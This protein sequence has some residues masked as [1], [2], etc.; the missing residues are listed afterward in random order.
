[1]Q[2]P[3]NTENTMNQG[4]DRP[5]RGVLARIGPGRDTWRW[6]GQQL[7]NREN[8]AMYFDPLLESINPLWA[9]RYIPARVE[10]IEAE[11]HDSKT[12]TLR[13]ARRW[14][15]FRAGQHL[16]L[17][18]EKDGRWYSRPF[19]LSCA[20][21]HWE[22]DGTITVTIKK[23]ADGEI[24]PWLLENFEPGDVIGISRA[25]GEDHTPEPG[26]PMLFI[27][28]GSGIT[29]VLSQLEA[30]ADRHLRNPVTLLYFVRTEADVIGGRK[31]EALAERLPNL[32][33]RIV[34]AEQDPQNPDHLGP[35]HLQAVEGLTE[36]ECFL[37]GPPGLM[38]HAENL[39]A[40]AGV[41]EEQVRST[42]FAVGP[43]VVVTEDAG[44]TVHFS[45]SDITV[46]SAGDRR[47]LE[48]AEAAGLN[49]R[50]G[51]RMGICHQCACRKK[52]GIVINQQTGQPSGHGEETVQLCISVPQGAVELEL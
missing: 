6:L 15:G 30:M 31:L 49:P 51:C 52:S 5:Y 36:R 50:Y 43:G 44:G 4:L 25:Y 11:T 42:L 19:S 3:M 47:L 1:M 8:P 17:E 21:S 33:L 29:P 12:L 39:L 13:P 16:N 28:G 32:D 48:E 23:V 46:E 34:A 9:Q 35:H 38:K 24:T 40:E 22:Q 45:R 37:C 7:F 26:H 18:V 14:G 27:T 41:P 10:A 2:E 20:P